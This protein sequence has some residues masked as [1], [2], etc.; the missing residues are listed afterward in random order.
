MGFEIQTGVRD[1]S[2]GE[3]CIKGT[4]EVNLSAGKREVETAHK[5]ACIAHSPFVCKRCNEMS[6]RWACI[7]Q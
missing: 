6:W 1:T 7:G 5:T 3:K 4:V 2:W